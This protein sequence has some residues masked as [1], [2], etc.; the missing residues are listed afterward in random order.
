MESK[1]KNL[2]FPCDRDG[3]LAL[4]PHR[5]PFVWVSRILECDPAAHIVAELD[6]DADLPL[7]KGHFPEKPVLPGVIIMEALAQ[8]SCCCIMASDSY[9]GSI[10]LFAAMDKVRFRAQ[11][12]PG[13]TLRLEST[14]VKRGSRMCAAQVVARVGD[15]V[16]AEAEPRYVIDRSATD[17]AAG[18]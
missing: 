10:G 6:V 15:T 13:Q 5:D 14:I 11:V 16:C 2:Q 4:I 8:A 17:T 7:F 18:E 3:V 12:L 9:A 1:E